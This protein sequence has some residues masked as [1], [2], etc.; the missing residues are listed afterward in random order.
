MALT[1]TNKRISVIGDL[2]IA[3]AR[4]T[5]TGVTSG[6]WVTGLKKILAFSIEDKTASTR[7]LTV[8][9]TSTEGT[10][11]VGSVTAADVC[12]VICIGY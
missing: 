1:L 11:A 6:S 7:A 9:T 2:K 12:E 4:M 10:I 5:F 3:V 8:D